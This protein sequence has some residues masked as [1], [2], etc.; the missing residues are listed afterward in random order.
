MPVKHTLT[1]EIHK[2][3]KSGTTGCSTS[4]KEYPSQWVYTRN[5]ITCEKSGCRN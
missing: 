2:E 3:T 4:I 1:K 5:K